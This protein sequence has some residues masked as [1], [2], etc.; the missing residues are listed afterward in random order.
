MLVYGGEVRT[1][2]ETRLRRQA[3]HCCLKR[4]ACLVHLKRRHSHIVHVLL[5]AQ[6]KG[7]L[8]DIFIAYDA[9]IRVVYIGSTIL[10]VILWIFSSQS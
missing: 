3:R 7:L 6:L 2:C 4:G 8:K 9:D 1:L 5:L 10:L